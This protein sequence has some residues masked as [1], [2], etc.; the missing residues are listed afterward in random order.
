MPRPRRA[1]RLLSP[2]LS[3][4]VALGACVP[5]GAPRVA[6]RG[7]LQPGGEGPAAAETGA[8][9]VVQAVP[10]GELREVPEVSITFSRPL[11]S[12]DGSSPP[13]PVRMMP[14]PAGSWDWVGTRALRFSPEK[15]LPAATSYE[16]EVRGARSLDG[17]TLEPYR[18]AF[19]TPRPR[20][21]SASPAH[22]ARGLRPD[23]T[24]RLTFNQPVDD[25]GVRAAV[26]LG[27]ADGDRA[28][29]A[30]DLRRPDAAD[31]RRVELVPRAPLAVHAAYETRVDARLRGTEGPLEAGAS[32]VQT[33]HTYDELTATLDCDDRGRRCAPGDGVTVRL[34]NPVRRSDLR[35]AVVIEPAVKVDWPAWQNEKETTSY[36]RLEGAF[37]P[38][39]RYTVRVRPGLRDVHGQTLARELAR[40]FEVSDLPAAFHVGV[41]GGVLE[42]SEVRE[43]PLSA[44]NLP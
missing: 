42:P 4:L 20:V 43:V 7:T 11:R 33:F 41:R 15:A 3:L 29:V 8:F 30:F 34:N 35:R 21:V 28:P 5:G 9:A 22:D 40:S 6:P 31:L 19:S 32:H 16:V 12:L 37:L 14:Q 1:L 18:F 10:T 2:S 44:M 36:L 26:S 13:P 17:A 24:V 23:A 27:R 38:G 39:R 25:A